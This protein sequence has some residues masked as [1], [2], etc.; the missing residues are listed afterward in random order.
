[1]SE[2]ITGVTM[3]DDGHIIIICVASGKILVS[4]DDCQSFNTLDESQPWSAIALSED[5]Q[6][7][8]AI[9]PTAIY[10]SNGRRINI[11]SRNT[12]MSGYYGSMAELM[13]LNGTQWMT[14][15]THAL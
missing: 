12:S 3:S 10:H 15:D 13:S 9:T 7:L 2:V 11:M 8:T 6:Y 5:G 14:V 1:V 4:V